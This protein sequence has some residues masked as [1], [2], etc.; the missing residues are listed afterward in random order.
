MIRR[1]FCFLEGIGR[2]REHDIWQQGIKS[3]DDFLNTP[4]IRGISNQKKEMLDKKVLE[5]KEKLESQDFAYFCRCLPRSEQWRLYRYCKNQIAFLDIETTGLSYQNE[6]TAVSLY[7]GKKIKTLISGFDLEE[8]RLRGLLDQY[9]MIV[10]FNGSLFDLP[11]IKKKFPSVNL[12][13]PHMDLRFCGERVGLS[14]G[15]KKI[16]KDLG[17]VRPESIQEVN[18]YEAVMLWR[19]W[20]IQHDH[21]ALDK[22]I[23]YNQ[24]DVLNL[25]RLADI[26]YQRLYDITTLKS[27]NR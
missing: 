26:V 21:E 2:I 22:L 9:D 15:L 10:T 25:K 1:T 5:A 8:K 19:R 23:K 17:F 27:K 20:E 18:G 4:N 24:Q 6:I 13:I 16:E 7:D 11:F 14:G 12:D 3:W